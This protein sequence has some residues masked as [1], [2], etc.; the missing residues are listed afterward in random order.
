MTS[1][2]V[3]TACRQLYYLTNSEKVHF[4]NRSTVL[5]VWSPEYPFPPFWHACLSGHSVSYLCM[6]KGGFIEYQ[7]HRIN[8]FLV[9]SELFMTEFHRNPAQH[10]S[11]LNWALNLSSGF[12]NYLGNRLCVSLVTLKL[13]KQAW[14]HRRVY[15]LA[16]GILFKV[17]K[18]LSNFPGCQSILVYKMKCLYM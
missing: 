2:Q 11:L 18:V 3:K 1:V 7:N 4:F 6:R 17:W 16:I 8:S 10:N 5:Q 9:Q 15:I 13:C 12:S 14:L